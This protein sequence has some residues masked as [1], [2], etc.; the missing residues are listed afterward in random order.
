MD[1]LSTGT[2]NTKQIFLLFFC[3]MTYVYFYIKK[4]L[5]FHENNV[6]DLEYRLVSVNGMS[7]HVD[8]HNNFMRS[9]LLIKV[10]K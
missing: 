6:E 4:C 2:T 7:K 8:C 1:V 9:F 10:Y 3:L 5:T